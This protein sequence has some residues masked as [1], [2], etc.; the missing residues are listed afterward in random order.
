MCHK[1]DDIRQ[2]MKNSDML[3]LRHEDFVENPRGSLHDICCFLG[4]ETDEEYL[5]ACA[6]I[7]YSSSVKSRYEIEWPPDLIDA[8]RNKISI[9]DF[10]KG[11]SY[12]D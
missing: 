1:T 7:V 8:V 11:Y 9:F 12:E 2:S 10:L 5:N 4:V 6:A 3:F